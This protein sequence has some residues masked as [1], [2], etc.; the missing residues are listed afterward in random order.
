MRSEA[1]AVD[2]YLR[3]LSEVRRAAIESV[4]VDVFTAIYEKARNAPR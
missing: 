4:P 2:Q 3:E 1:T